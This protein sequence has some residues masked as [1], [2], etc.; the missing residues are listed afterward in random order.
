M[1]NAV[2]NQSNGK[3]KSEAFNAYKNAK[4]PVAKYSRHATESIVTETPKY[5]SIHLLEC[6]SIDD[7]QVRSNSVTPSSEFDDK[8]NSIKDDSKSKFDI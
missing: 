3:G 2:E 5:D 7:I 8:T 6:K 1:A 4:I